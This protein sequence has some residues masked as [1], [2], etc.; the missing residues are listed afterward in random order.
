MIAAPLGAASFGTVRVLWLCRSRTARRDRVASQPE[1][2]TTGPDTP[3]SADL[4]LI[5][6][7]RAGD[8][9][10]FRDLLLATNSGLV[11]VAEQYVATR[12]VAEEVVQDTW[13]AVIRGLDRFE[14]RSSLRTWIYR[15]LTNIAQT[16]G[17]REKRTVP[18]SSIAGGGAD[19]PSHAQP[20]VEAARFRSA[21]HLFNGHWAQPPTSFRTLPEERLTTK[22]TTTAIENAIAVLPPNQQR[23]V[24]LRDV[25]GWTSEEV[26]DA[27]GLSEANQRVLL[28]RARSKVRATLERH[29]S[30][31][32]AGT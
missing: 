7:L 25:E 12:A 30:P 20:T 22:E 28:H 27:L 29:L 8:Q 16:R 13:L 26:C 18:F 14:G 11:R 31:V 6:R 5:E 32:E 1:R 19:D 21:D 3:H 15:I 4:V 17:A 9:Q 10:A 23:V 24:W 2:P